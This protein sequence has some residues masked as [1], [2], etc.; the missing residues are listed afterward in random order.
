M[1]LLSLGLKKYEVPLQIHLLIW[2]LQILLVLEEFTC[3]ELYSIEFSF[4]I[5][6]PYQI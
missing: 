3:A 4:M 1:T 6:V 2:L 5:V